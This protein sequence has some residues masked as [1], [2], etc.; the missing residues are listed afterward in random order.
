MLEWPSKW[1]IRR[2]ARAPRS[3]QSQ[4]VPTLSSLLAR[5]DDFCAR[6]AWIIVVLAGLLAVA[7]DRIIGPDPVYDEEDETSEE[8]VAA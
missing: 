6:R 2:F 5:L 4:D 8:Q 7:C 3:N 1:Q